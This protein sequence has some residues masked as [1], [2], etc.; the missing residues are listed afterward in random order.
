M[1]CKQIC[2]D[3]L[4][5][6]FC[7]LESYPK[8]EI[9]HYIN[10]T[11]EPVACQRVFVTIDDVRSGKSPDFM[12]SLLLWLTW[13]LAS[14]PGGGVTLLSLGLLK[15]NALL[16]KCSQWGMKP[17]GERNRIKQRPCPK[18][19]R[20]DSSTFGVSRNLKLALHSWSAVF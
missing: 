14:F 20:H 3:K 17:C 15:Q 1:H 12:T 5:K 2:F 16:L 7:T 18:E 13:S 19:S 9:C 6:I 4:V 10:M 8:K 11:S